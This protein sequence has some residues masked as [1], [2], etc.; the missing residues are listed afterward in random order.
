MAVDNP[1]HGEETEA[2]DAL[3]VAM[4]AG[5]LEIEQSLCVGPDG[6]RQE[7]IDEG[8]GVLGV[9]YVCALV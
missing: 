7:P 2:V 4:G 8:R 3:E 6:K 5:G 9:L 1:N